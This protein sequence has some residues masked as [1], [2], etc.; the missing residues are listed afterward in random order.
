MDNYNNFANNLRR[1]MNEQKLTGEKLAERIGVSKGTV[2]HWSNGTRFP[3]EDSITQLV[4]SLKVT[5]NELFGVDK[6]GIN[7]VPLVGKASCGIPQDYDLNGYEP[8]PVPND[9]YK[10]GMYALEAEGNSMSPKINEGDIVY[11]CPSQ[12]VDSGNIVHYWLDGESGIKRYKINES[13]TIISL[14]PINSEHDI[15]TIHH[16]ENVDLK[17]ARIVGKI[18]KDF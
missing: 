14:I 16:D 18:D 8:V 7:Y 4:T 11:C 3:K 13:G 17:M 15:I 9:M 12:H 6:L 10:S 5:Y 1:I 2:I